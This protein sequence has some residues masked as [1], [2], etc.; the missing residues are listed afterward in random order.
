[1]PAC[2]LYERQQVAA[3]KEQQKCTFLIQV[4]SFP[5]QAATDGKHRCGSACACWLVVFILRFK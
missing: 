3:I 1:M 5:V 2:Y 4:C